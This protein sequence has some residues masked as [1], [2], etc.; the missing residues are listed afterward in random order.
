MKG[1]LDGGCRELVARAAG[2]RAGWR[3]QFLDIP[4]RLAAFAA[5]WER[6]HHMPM[7]EPVGPR[8]P[9]VFADL[10]S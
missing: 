1:L 5:D 8:L 6:A 2:G 7:R 4:E 9:P 3:V 10:W